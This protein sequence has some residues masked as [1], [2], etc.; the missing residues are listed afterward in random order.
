MNAKPTVAS[1]VAQARAATHAA[2]RAPTLAAVI[3]NLET[4]HFAMAQA[5]R[6]KRQ[7]V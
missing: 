6:L 7:H 4:A 1:C 3:E 2:L 5:R